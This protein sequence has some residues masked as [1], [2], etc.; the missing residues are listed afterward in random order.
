MK[1]IY[2][3]ISLLIFTVIILASGYILNTTGII[4]I[5]LNHLIILSCFFTLISFITLIIFFRGQGK[6]PDSQTLHSL[7]AMSIKLLLEML[8]ALVW[9]I[10]AK[11]INL[12]SVL[13]FFVLYLSF[14]LYSITI[15]LKT[16]KNR[17][18]DNIY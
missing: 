4:I 10:I 2:S 15:I 18:L 1:N 9:F 14:T 7:V 8:L 12:P 6:K 13:L 17:P 5:N 3:Y 16:L 11:K